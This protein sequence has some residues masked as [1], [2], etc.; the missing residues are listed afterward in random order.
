VASAGEGASPI[1]RRAGLV[2]MHPG[3]PP[4]V[5]DVPRR[6]THMDNNGLVMTNLAWN[7][8]WINRAGVYNAVHYIRGENCDGHDQCSGAG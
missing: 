6:F 3:L 8:T 7:H 5:L 4:E 1:K 2:R